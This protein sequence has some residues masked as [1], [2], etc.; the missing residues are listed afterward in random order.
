MTPPPEESAQLLAAG[1]RDRLAFRILNDHAESPDEIVLFHAQQAA[2]K[3]IK[4]VLAA[5]GIIYRRTHDLFELSSL[6]AQQGL[7]VPVEQELL[8]RMGPYAVEFR[9]L[10]LSAPEVSRGE[11]EAMIENL[12]AWAQAVIEG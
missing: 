8:V 6:V 3:F 12:R 10:G 4:A 1:D 9:Y 5:R 11:A 7:Q 2:E